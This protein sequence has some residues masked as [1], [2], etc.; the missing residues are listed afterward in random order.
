MRGGSLA[1]RP[2]Q[3]CSPC[4]PPQ[5]QNWQL[6]HIA[7]WE[8]EREREGGREGGREGV[9]IG[10]SMDDQVS[11]EP[12]CRSCDCQVTHRQ[13]SILL[14]CSVL[15]GPRNRTSQPLSPD[16]FTS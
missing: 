5:T 15:G 7:P 10:V 12:M 1:G 3:R 16:R 2:P 4:N 14:M 8:R 11:N 9:G 13:A 6:D